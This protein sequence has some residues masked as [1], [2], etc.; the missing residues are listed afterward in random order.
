MI[1]M[2]IVLLS[3]LALMIS[4]T[5]TTA[6]PPNRLGIAI[7]SISG[8]YTNKDPS[9]SDA[10]LAGNYSE[11]PVYAY[12]FKNNIVLGVKYIDLSITGNTSHTAIPVP[13][14][15]TYKLTTFAFLFGYNFQVNDKLSVIPHVLYGEG[16]VEAKAEVLG[17]TSSK[18]GTGNI[19]AIAIPLVFG[20]NENI[21][22]GGQY[23]AGNGG[24]TTK[25]NSGYDV[26]I[27]LGS[28][29]QFII[30]GRF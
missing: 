29:F 25:N 27:I 9:V 18:T 15:I 6:E 22:I 11:F 21:Y 17:F 19:L 24:S 5:L 1:Y 2:R 30:G 16:N 10:S 7:G 23:L 4:S 26:D 28:G 3:I 14:N 12:T 20:L 8:N 13:A